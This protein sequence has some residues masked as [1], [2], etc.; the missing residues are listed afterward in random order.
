MMKGVAKDCVLPCKEAAYI[1][2]IVN[3][4][5]GLAFN[6]PSMQNIR[7]INHVS[8]IFG[9]LAARLSA[10]RI[11]TKK[12]PRSAGWQGLLRCIEWLPDGQNRTGHA[13]AGDGSSLSGP[14][15]AA[16]DA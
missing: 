12:P 11:N 16:H 14:R 10:C 6:C 4:S 13:Q 1:Q 2:K 5:P 7:K 15:S 3:K 9:L 8:K